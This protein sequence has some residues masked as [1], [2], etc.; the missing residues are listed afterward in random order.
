MPQQS[1]SGQDSQRLPKGHQEDG[2]TPRYPFNQVYVSESGHEVHFDNTPGKERM[3]FGH[4]SGTYM[5]IGPDGSMK[6]FS[7]GQNVQ[8]HKGGMSMTVNQNHDAKISGHHRFNVDGGSHV[9]VAGDA[10][11]VTA[12]NSQSVVGGNSKTATAGNSYQGVKGDHNTNVSGSM[13]MKTKGGITM[14]GGSSFN[15]KGNV[16]INGIKQV[17]D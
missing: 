11:I 4:K 6:S 5:E 12:G 16:Q 15:L 2:S 10:N 1:G 3:F 13:N 14:E 7:V 9:E 17:S 8:Y